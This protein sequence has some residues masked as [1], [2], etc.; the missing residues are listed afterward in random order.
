MKIK[1]CGNSSANSL[2]TSRDIS[3]QNSGSKEID[4]DGLKL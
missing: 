2:S 4:P 3:D 1:K